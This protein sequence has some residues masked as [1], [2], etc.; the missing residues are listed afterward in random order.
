M[1]RIAARS[2]RAPEQISDP[3]LISVVTATFDYP[4]V[5]RYAI[6]SVR[7]QS[8]P[9]WEHI[10][11][12]DGCGPETGRLVDSYS[13]VDPRVRFVSL[14][15]NSG[16]QSVPNNAGIK[17]ARGRYVAY[18][19]H[20]DLWSR[21]HLAWLALTARETEA[22][23]VHSLLE[24]I[25]PRG[26]GL[27]SLGGLS[28]S[29]DY[30][31]GLW[32]GPSSVMHRRELAERIGGWRGHEAIDLT[33]DLDFL[34]RANEAGA[35]FRSSGAMTAFKF[36]AVMRRNVYLDKPSHEQAELWRRIRTERLFAYRELGR[37][38]RARLTQ[39]EAELDRLMLRRLAKDGRGA[40]VRE[41]RR[42]RG[43]DP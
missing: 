39:D 20:D 41:S 34:T 17:A 19:G 9:D 4:E 1:A 3:P 2:A 43:L 35:R 8:Y 33:P 26:S 14:D 42:V 36:P 7:A 37:L 27:R 22:D 13:R 40:W 10:V 18:L 12:G 15:V 28:A 11:V 38:V 23:V 29:G 25:G 24:L 6:E 32:I 31:P 5:L 21:H 16:S 30:E